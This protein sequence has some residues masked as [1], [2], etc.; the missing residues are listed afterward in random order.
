MLP[1][2]GRRHARRLA[3]P[4]RWRP[5]ATAG[6]T[7][8]EH[9]QPH[10]VRASRTIR[11]NDRPN[12]VY[13]SPTPMSAPQSWLESSVPAKPTQASPTTTSPSTHSTN[14]SYYVATGA[15]VLVGPKLSKHLTLR[16]PFPLKPYPIFYPSLLARYPAFLSPISSITACDNTDTNT[17][18]CLFDYLPT[19]F[20]L[21]SAQAARPAPNRSRTQHR[22]SGEPTADL[23][24]VGRPTATLSEQH[25]PEATGTAGQRQKTSHY[26][27]ERLARLVW[28]QRCR[29]HDRD[30]I[31]RYVT[32]YSF[33]LA[34]VRLRPVAVAPLAPMWQRSYARTPVNPSVNQTAPTSF[35]IRALYVVLHRRCI[36]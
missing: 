10:A 9:E 5:V 25:H 29:H 28:A 13:P 21:L 22:P 31:T 24:L 15:A 20:S 36:R 4:G 12:R 17:G 11:G 30:H 26:I 3:L 19:H 35:S 2:Q 27:R 1:R 32:C 33:A 7:S 16:H 6:A 23:C 8:Q 34:C 18:S 14:S